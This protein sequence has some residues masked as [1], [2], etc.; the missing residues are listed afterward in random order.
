MVQKYTIITT[1]V[2]RLVYSK[3]KRHEKW[4][5]TMYRGKVVGQSSVVLFWSRTDGL[6]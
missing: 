2:N 6:S 3:S 5:D 1:A 4:R